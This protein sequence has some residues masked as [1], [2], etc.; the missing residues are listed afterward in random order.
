M[1]LCNVKINGIFGDRRGYKDG[2]TTNGGREA[3]SGGQ[4]GRGIL[5]QRKGRSVLTLNINRDPV[6]SH[7]DAQRRRQCGRGPSNT[8]G[9]IEA[10]RALRAFSGKTIMHAEFYCSAQLHQC[11]PLS[12]R[13]PLR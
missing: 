11:R 3:G 2:G 10:R 4:R 7:G 13:L 12:L 5:K 1:T 9:D 6:P 8:S